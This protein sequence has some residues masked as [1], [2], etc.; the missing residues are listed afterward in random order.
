MPSWQLR[1]RS[2]TRPLREACAWLLPG[3]DPAFWCDVVL[4]YGID[5][6]DVRLLLIPKTAHD[7]TPQSALILWQ[8]HERMPDT[9]LWPHY[10]K[11]AGCLYLP[12]EGQLE[13]QV[14]DAD[15]SPLLI[16]HARSYVLHP[17][18]GLIVYE[19]EDHLQVDQ[20]FVR[21]PPPS[22]DW[23]FARTGIYVNERLW[24]IATEART[25]LEDLLR[26]ASDDIGSEDPM[27]M[28]DALMDTGGESSES[29]AKPHEGE[30]A[31][32]RTWRKIQSTVRGRWRRVVRRLKPQQAFYQLRELLEKNPDAGLRYAPPL[33]DQDHRARPDTGQDAG[34]QLFGRDIR[35]RVSNLNKSSWGGPHSTIPNDAFYDLRRIY[36]ELAMRELRL[37]RHRRAAYILGYLLNDLHHAARVLADGGY[38][39]EAAEVYLKVNHPQA[40]AE[41]FENGG[42][43]QE[44]IDLLEQIGN[45]AQLARLYKLL[46]DED[47]ARGAFRR[48]ADRL[49]KEDNYLASA[50]I[51]ANDLQD[52]DGALA[53][54]EAGIRWG[55]TAP[56]DKSPQAE[57]LVAC[58]RELWKHRDERREHDWMRRWI[59]D[60]RA[61]PSTPLSF[62]LLEELAGF[63][64]STSDDSLRGF[65]ADT[66]RVIASNLLR[67]GETSRRRILRCVQALDSND[68]LLHRDC[69]RYLQPAKPKKPLPALVGSLP[70][71]ATSRLPTAERWV[72]A[73]SDMYSF[74]AL[75]ITYSHNFLCLC[76]V[77]GSWK[78]DPSKWH[79]QVYDDQRMG[80]LTS[81]L[82]L[83]PNPDAADTL[84]LFSTSRGGL[85][86]PE[87]PAMDGL[88]PLTI[89]TP[90]WLPVRT[91]AL[92]TVDGHWM[93]VE[94]KSADHLILS[95]WMAGKLVQTRQ[96]EHLTTQG[97]K[98]FVRIHRGQVCVA[99]GQV[100]EII[101]SSRSSL[102][103]H[104]P[105]EIRSAF[106]VGSQALF[107]M[108]DDT[109][110][111]D[112]LHAIRDEGAQRPLQIL[113]EGLRD[114][115]ARQIR[116]DLILV[117]HREGNLLFRLRGETA[118]EVASHLEANS[119][120]SAIL[121]TNEP[122]QFV[123]LRESGNL[124]RLAVKP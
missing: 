13:P 3:S 78:T 82:I 64:K 118:F 8:H 91:I 63:A 15:L 22:V 101:E 55:Q 112:H 62:I 18:A 11:M 113:Q 74:V 33:R 65:A 97:E 4:R 42:F 106:R 44:A 57:Q 45:F 96:L 104:Y 110:Y 9:H 10:G 23:S 66:T 89:K 30:N 38:Y 121:T 124:Q 21:R 49:E 40:A 109:I 28:D 70:V 87:L 56:H 54:L 73:L 43:W 107:V 86:L 25:S 2:A 102:A 81:S 53:V 98:A 114:P 69:D 76:S 115:L 50:E 94:R 68:L 36:R 72:C 7:R 90:W 6:D 32:E 92:T 79:M 93:C 48:L 39:H 84:C 52:P 41:C 46:G 59:G 80:R 100:L 95:T 26:E 1:M 77:R 83:E 34:F 105:S 16:Q 67:R 5:V 58:L 120:P 99:C 20:L 88:P 123:V 71:I 47:A 31:V 14:S 75:G 35:F 12:V 111:L 61:A 37:G 85:D 60:F 108:T 24:T 51:W 19:E 29:D 119:P 116:H 122:N 103:A 17:T 27:A 117:A